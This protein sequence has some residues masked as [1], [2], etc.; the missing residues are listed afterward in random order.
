[1]L[2]LYFLFSVAMEYRLAA[3]P[4]MIF[5]DDLLHCWIAVSTFRLALILVT[6]TYVLEASCVCSLTSSMNS[7]VGY[8][9]MVTLYWSFFSHKIHSQQLTSFIIY[10]VKT[11]IHPILIRLLSPFLVA[12]NSASKW[13]EFERIMKK[14]SR[15]RCYIE[16]ILLIEGID[17]THIKNNS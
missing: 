16:G 11:D 10:F 15:N 8:I 4:S 14:K 9:L 6:L 7:S 5:A 3:A 2:F 13:I 12:V 1:M 17:V